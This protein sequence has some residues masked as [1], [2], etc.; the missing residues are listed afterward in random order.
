ML[1][2]VLSYRKPVLRMTFDNAVVE[3]VCYLTLTGIGR[4]G[5]GGMKLTP[6]AQPDGDNFYISI[7]K[8]FSKFD[9]VRYIGKLYDGSFVEMDKAEAHYSKHVRIEVISSEDEVY[10]EADGDMVGTGPFEISLIPM[11]LRVVIP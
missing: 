9:T 10:M 11:A 7:A 4:Y 6:G 5:G 8:D 1:S 2:S 3:T